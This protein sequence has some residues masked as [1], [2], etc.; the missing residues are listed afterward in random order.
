MADA[1]AETVRELLNTSSSLYHEDRKVLETALNQPA[2]G[3]GW[4]PD[5][6][7]LRL[8]EVL[9]LV[10][11]SRAT[12]YNLM[13]DGAFPE[14]VKLTGHVVG[15][16]VKDIRAWLKSPTGWAFGRCV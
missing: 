13:S 14:A 9:Q 1:L 8:A 3:W 5:E 2:T 15:W 4:P 16:R 11:L 10:A 6:A 7:F 12:I